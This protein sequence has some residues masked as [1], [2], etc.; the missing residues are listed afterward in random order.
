MFISDRKTEQT[1]VIVGNQWL[2]QNRQPPVDC[3]GYQFR[4]KET[5]KKCWFASFTFKNIATKAHFVLSK[6]PILLNKITIV[7]QER[8]ISEGISLFHVVEKMCTRGGTMS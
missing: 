8:G 1:Q 2:A 4:T 5:H 6:Y 7:G 3:V